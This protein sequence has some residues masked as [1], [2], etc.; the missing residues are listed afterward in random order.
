[1]S[2]KSQVTSHPSRETLAACAG[3]TAAGDLGH[4]HEISQTFVRGLRGYG[5]YGGVT[6]TVH[7]GY[8]DSALG[9]TVTVH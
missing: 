5:G 7:W 6:V 1:M 8:G 2:L 3:S 4:V 9:V